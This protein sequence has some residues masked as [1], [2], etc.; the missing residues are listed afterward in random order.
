MPQNNMEDAPLAVCT[1]KITR[2]EDSL[3]EIIPCLLYTSLPEI[4]VSVC[5]LFQIWL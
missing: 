3:N 1:D 4:G 2:L 5:R